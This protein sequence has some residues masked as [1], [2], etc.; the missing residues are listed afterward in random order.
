MYGVT[1]APF[2]SAICIFSDATRTCHLPHRFLGCDTATPPQPPTISE[3]HRPEHYCRPLLGRAVTVGTWMLLQPLY[4]CGKRRSVPVQSRKVQLQVPIRLYCDNRNLNRITASLRSVVFV[5][6]SCESNPARSQSAFSWNGRIKEFRNSDTFSQVQLSVSSPQPRTRRARGVKV[7]SYCA[8][9]SGEYIDS[10]I[11]YNLAPGPLNS[12]EEG[13][14]R[15]GI[16][17][18]PPYV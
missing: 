5:S 2:S 6:T 10:E 1:A 7:G 13:S 3:K 14:K 17:C 9:A 15:S 4:A 11:V 12:L 16:F 8:V 18:F